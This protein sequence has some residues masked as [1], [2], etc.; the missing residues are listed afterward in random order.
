MGVLAWLWARH[1]GD[2]RPLRT[3]LAGVNVVSLAIFWLLPVAP[4]RMLPGMTDVVA[5]TGAPGSWHS[6]SLATHANELAAMPSLHIAW[7]V[8]SAWAVWRVVR[9]RTRWAGLVWAYP[10][11]TTLTVL[12]TGNHFVADVVAGAVLTA[13]V[14]PLSDRLAAFHVRVLLH[15]HRRRQER[16]SQPADVLAPVRGGMAS[17]R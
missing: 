11:A 8:W 17:T 1:P 5:A 15:L 10:V 12:S 7:A 6:G 16:A 13:A 3:A 4:P 14:V 2:Y 9:R